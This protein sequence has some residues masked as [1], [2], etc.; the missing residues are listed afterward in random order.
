M[1]K[2]KLYLIIVHLLIKDE[3][4]SSFKSPVLTIIQ[5]DKDIKEKG[6][7]RQNIILKEEPLTEAP[8]IKINSEN[9][10]FE[11]IEKKGDLYFSFNKNQ[12]QHKN[13]LL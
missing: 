1:Y 3:Q 8:R 4:N 9:F 5:V 7:R 11:F 2:N 6:I 10:K 13:K 12:I